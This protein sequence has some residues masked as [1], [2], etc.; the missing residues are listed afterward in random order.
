LAVA[1]SDFSRGAFAFQ[2]FEH[3]GM[4]I[5]EIGEAAI[6]RLLAHLQ[7]PQNELRQ[8]LVDLDDEQENW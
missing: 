8:Q 7:K 5:G 3:A 1:E 6:Q 4:Q 2:E